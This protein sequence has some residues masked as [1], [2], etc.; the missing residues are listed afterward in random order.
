MRADQLIGVTSIL[1][2]D[3][4]AVSSVGLT[5]S[6]NNIVPGTQASLY[7]SF[8]H[9]PRVNSTNAKGEAHLH[10]NG[11]GQ[12]SRIYFSVRQISRS[13][14]VQSRFLFIV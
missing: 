5:T 2:V 9:I 14:M 7:N 3:C 1:L 11:C 10:L 12:S 4:K 8:Q 6:M 13:Y